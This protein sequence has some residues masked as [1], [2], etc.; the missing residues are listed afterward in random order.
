MFYLLRTKYRR[1][2]DLLM[3][4]SQ[5]EILSLCYYFPYYSDHLLDHI[6]IHLFFILIIVS[7][8]WQTHYPF[9]EFSIQS[10]LNP[11]MIH[12]AC[13]ANSSLNWIK[14]YD[15]QQIYVTNVGGG[16]VNTLGVLN[17]CQFSYIYL[18]STHLSNILPFSNM[19]VSCP[20]L[21]PFQSF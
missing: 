8:F 6:K 3:S 14:A 7:F 12:D 13:H 5:S 17:D 19:N 10:K 20:S 15:C 21:A 16:Y 9:G 11:N 4:L 18:V 2:F 1:K